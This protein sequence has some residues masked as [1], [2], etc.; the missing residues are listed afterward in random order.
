MTIA[1]VNIAERIH[2]PSISTLKGKRALQTPKPIIADE[3]EI[4]P[5]LLM[6][7]GQIELCMDTMFVNYKGILTTIDKTMRFHSSV[8]IKA[9]TAN[10]YI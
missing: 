9:R 5:E 8:P 6:N 2:G 3:V 10:E 1:N 4:P 7:H